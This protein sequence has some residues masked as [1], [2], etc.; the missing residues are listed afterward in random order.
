MIARLKLKSTIDATDANETMEFYNVILQQLDQIVNVTT[1]PSDETFECCISVLRASPFAIRFDE[2][3]RSVC[4]KN[5]RVRRYIG[6]KYKLRVEVYDRISRR[7]D[8]LLNAQRNRNQL[9]IVD[10]FAHPLPVRVI[11]KMLGVPI[12]DKAR[13][14]VWVSALIRTVE[15]L[16]NVNEAEVEERGSQ[17]AIEMREYLRDLIITLRDRPGDD[18]VT[19]TSQGTYR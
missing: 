5:D 11:S 3:I 4:A 17:A 6:E 10:D 1:D 9:D 14:E 19:R 18:S 2:V 15:P 16:Q 13:F 12:Q 8:E 7:V